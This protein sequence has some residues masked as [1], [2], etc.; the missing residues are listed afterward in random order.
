MS[1]STTTA[2]DVRLPMSQEPGG[3]AGRLLALAFGLSLAYTVLTTAM[4]TAPS[5][6]DATTPTVWFGYLIGGTAVVL[7]PRPER[8]ARWIVRAIVVTFL[9][10]AVLVY[11]HYFTA[12]HQDTLGWFENDA[13]VVLLAIALREHLRWKTA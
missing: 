2:R 4:H 8:W 7:A 10:A 3:H 11:P 1:T 6:F 9:A 13:Y 5:D 12:D